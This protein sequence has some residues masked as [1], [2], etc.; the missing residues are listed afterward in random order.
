MSPPLSSSRYP[1]A[2]ALARGAHLDYQNHDGISM[3]RFVAY[4]MVD[5]CPEC[6]GYQPATCLRCHVVARLLNAE[7]RR[8]ARWPEPMS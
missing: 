8:G 3:E 5:P 7:E 2:I 6:G 4:L 1:W